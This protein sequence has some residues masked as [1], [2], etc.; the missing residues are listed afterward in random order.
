MCKEGAF[1]YEWL[2]GC[3]YPVKS[4]GTPEPEMDCGAP[5]VARAWWDQSE[6]EDEYEATDV[7]LLCEEHLQHV[8]ACEAREKI[9]NKWVKGQ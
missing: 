7:M 4:T 9:M 8:L 3:Q 2:P 1:D 5:P 6:G